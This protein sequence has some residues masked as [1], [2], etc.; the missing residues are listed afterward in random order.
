M[1]VLILGGLGYMG[2]KIYD[3]PAMPQTVSVMAIRAENGTPVTLYTVRPT[4]W[5]Y[6]LPLYGVVRTPRMA[7]VSASQQEYIIDIAAEVG[8][9]VVKGQ[10]LALLDNKTTMEKVSAARARERELAA[11]HQRLRTLQQAGGTSNQDVETAFTQYRDAQATL[12]GLATE[13][14]RKKVVAPIDGVVIKRDAEDGQLANPSRPLFAIA[15]TTQIEVALDIAP[16]YSLQIKPEMRASVLANETW[17]PAVVKRIDPLANEVTGLYHS[18]LTVISPEP[19][20]F[21]L[22][23]TVECQILLEETESAFVVPYE[24]IREVDGAPVVYVVKD[25]IAYER[26]IERGRAM[27]A[28]VR[29]T[30]GIESGEQLVYNGV[31]RMFDRTKVWVQNTE[32]TPERTASLIDED[33]V[34]MD[35]ALSQDLVPSAALPPFS[36]MPAEGE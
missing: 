5:Q 3:R 33:T 13:L 4:L 26:P 35:F 7:E 14:S 27:N 28:L 34:S 29:V 21:R 16:R 30:G 8:D 31:D 19:N 24:L 9:A 1:L 11:R 23:G 25:G 10:T 12:Q 2:W 15:D 20:M 22:G 18:V 32:I 6:R 17:T 36:P